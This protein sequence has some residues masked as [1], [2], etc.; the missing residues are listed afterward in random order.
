MNI[1][2]YCEV[3]FNGNLTFTT[4]QVT[5]VGQLTFPLTFDINGTGISLNSENFIA[6][7]VPIANEISRS[8]LTILIFDSSL[9][10]ILLECGFGKTVLC[11]LL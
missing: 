5:R 11:L 6:T 2:V 8:N 9:D 1:R 3:T 4:W 7:G 10:M